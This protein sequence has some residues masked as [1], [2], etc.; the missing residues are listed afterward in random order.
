MHARFVRHRWLNRLL[1]AAV[2]GSLGTVAV[3]SRSASAGIVTWNG[4]GGE[5]WADASWSNSTG[6]GTTDTA[7]FTDTASVQFPGTVTSILDST[8][9]IGGLAFTDTA[10]HY[11]TLDLGGFT[12]NEFGN[13]NFNTDENSSTT[14]T[15]RDGVLNVGG[16]FSS[17]NVGT[18]VS[19]SASGIADLSCAV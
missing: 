18:A 19:E 17:I 16:G 3:T 4:N 9:T 12:L 1:A 8:R 14:S 2:F 7:S 6:P 5:S 15:I 11:H 13:L 10:G